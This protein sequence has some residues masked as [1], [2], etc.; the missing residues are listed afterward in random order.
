MTTAAPEPRRDADVPDHARTRAQLLRRAAFA[1]ALMVLLAIGLALYEDDEP[2][3]G[4]LVEAPLPLTRARPAAD[5]AAGTPPAAAGSAS[6]RAGP[7]GPAHAAVG[8]QPSVAE[9]G[10]QAEDTASAPPAAGEASE[11][12]R[13]GVEAPAAAAEGG[14]E[15]DVPR[16]DPRS[17]TEPRAQAPDAPP[18]VTA[19]LETRADSARATAAAAEAAATEA[20]AAAETAAD[21][22]DAGATEAGAAVA[23]STRPEGARAP[24]PQSQ[25]L[26]RFQLEVGGFDD[27][28]QADR[29]RDVLDADGHA[30][31]VLTRVAVGPFPARAAARDALDRLRRERSLRG[32]LIAAPDGGL[33]VQVGVFADRGNAERLDRGLAEAGYPVVTHAR[34]VLGPYAGR[35][36]ADAVAAA[37]RDQ[38]GLDVA[39]KALR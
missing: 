28:A 36:A 32:V 29:L 33:L 14:E 15:G 24:S 23:A 39:V 31:R 11:A 2:A 25:A 6:E 30:A 5:T 7:G 16:A 20:A 10:V 3:P 26:A 9:S 19:A 34:I 1:A 35:S 17:A 4:P 18:A 8:A 12:A 22:A 27:I 38:H 37:L 13:I 21:A